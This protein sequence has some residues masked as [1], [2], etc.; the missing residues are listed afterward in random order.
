MPNPNGRKR[1]EARP[2][3]HGDTLYFERLLSKNNKSVFVLASMAMARA[4]EIHFGSRPLVE[5]SALDKETTI[6]LREIAQG[7][8][9]FKNNMIHKVKDAPD[10]DAGT[11]VPTTNE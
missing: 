10:E 6:A 2:N 8:I 1:P 9:I 7:K 3:E 4:K 5:F 11:P